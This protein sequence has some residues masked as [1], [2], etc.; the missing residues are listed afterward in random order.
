M[1]G[2]R[3][4]APPAQDGRADC[5]RPERHPRRAGGGTCVA[6]VGWVEFGFFDMFVYLV[7]ALVLADKTSTLKRLLTT[8]PTKKN[9]TSSSRSRWWTRPKKPPRRRPPP[10]AGSRRTGG[11]RAGPTAAGGAAA[12]GARG[13]VVGWGWAD[14]GCRRVDAA[15]WA[16][17]ARRK[18]RVS[19]HFVGG[20]FWVFWMM[21]DWWCL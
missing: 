11:A 8:P 16:G 19:R 2:G 3:A 9:R 13:A 10:P 1:G 6:R 5:E 21:V 17:P 18:G 12:A 20:G 4:D 15:A 14:G 7:P